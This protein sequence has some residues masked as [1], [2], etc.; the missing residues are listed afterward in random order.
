MKHTLLR[1]ISALLGASLLFAV[2]AIAA[3]IRVVV[4]DEAQPEQKDAY[5][6]FLGDAIADQ[7]FKDKD[8][9]VKS[10]HLDDPDQGLSDEIL[11]NCDVLI[12]WGHKRHKDVTAEHV[13]A[14]VDRLQSG[15]LNLL[16]L[17]SAHWSE[18]FMKAMCVRAM[19]D[20]WK[21][22]PEAE[23]DHVKPIMHGPVRVIPG[24]N[25]PMTPSSKR[26]TAGDGQKILEI[27]LPNC[28]F[29]IV[30]NEG[31]P[32]HLETLLPDHP[33]AKGIPATFDIPQT[34]KYAG[35]FHVPKPDAVI[36]EERWDDGDKF[37]SGCV[38][39]VGEGKVFYF[40]PGHETYAIYKQK[41]PMQIVSNAAKWLGKK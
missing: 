37:T 30:K 28:V 36:W 33:I 13:V 35:P 1:P 18:V 24:T 17:H 32:S 10:V 7:L 22:I 38:W 29:P 6:T 34:E 5:G 26:F 39:K 8:F 40:R 4:W 21:P 14:V 20:A 25:A 15:K 16:A 2:S 9:T 19:D 12:W 41:V 31:K 27:T 23:R 11:D 3:P